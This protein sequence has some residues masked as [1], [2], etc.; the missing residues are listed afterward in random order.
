MISRLIKS[1][2]RLKR[3]AAF[4]AELKEDEGLDDD[5]FGGIPSEQKNALR[6][7][8][9][10]QSPHLDD[11]SANDTEDKPPPQSGGLTPDLDE[12]EE[13]M[14]EAEPPKKKENRRKKDKKL[15]PSQIRTKKPDGDDEY[16]PSS[17]G[18]TDSICKNHNSP[19]HRSHYLRNG[20][21][22]KKSSPPNNIIFINNCINT[23]IIIDDD[24]NETSP[25]DYN[26]TGTFNVAPSLPLNTPTNTIESPFQNDSTTNESVADSTPFN[27]ALE[28]VDISSPTSEPVSITASLPYSNSRDVFLR[29]DYPLHPIPFQPGAANV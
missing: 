6:Q 18:S 23:A 11:G 26:S 17:S 2:Q 16:L 25:P 27:I 10:T 4:E 8:P 21:T 1:R 24:D 13:K 5:P 19:S 15:K 9:V 3:I 14:E 22:F 20:K 7:L 28:C 12:E 29:D